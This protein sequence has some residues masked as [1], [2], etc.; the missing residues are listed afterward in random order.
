MAS[1]PYW[2]MDSSAESSSSVQFYG[3]AWWCTQFWIFFLFFLNLLKSPPKTRQWLQIQLE[4]DSLSL[5]HQAWHCILDKFNL[6]AFCNTDID[7]SK[8][9]HAIFFFFFNLILSCK[10]QKGRKWV[11]RVLRYEDKLYHWAPEFS[12][13][14]VRWGLSWFSSPECLSVSRWD[15]F[16]LFIEFH[17]H[18]YIVLSEAWN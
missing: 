10:G 3:W 9:K 8:T 11:R 12:F 18:N 17:E 4:E 13:H 6:S 14:D 15:W 2:P 5:S 16:S 1:P 7:S